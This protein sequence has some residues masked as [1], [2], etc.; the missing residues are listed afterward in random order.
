[1]NYDFSKMRLSNR[2]KAP[3]FNF[4]LTI[5][6]LTVFAGI[7]TFLSAIFTFNILG[8]EQYLQLIVTLSILL[9]FILRGKQIFE[10]Y[11]DREVINFTN[12]NVFPFFNE[13]VSD[14][15]PKYKLVNFEIKNLVFLKRL[16]FSITSKKKNFITLKYDI[17]YLTKKNKRFEIFFK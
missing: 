16:Y 11:S 14:K 9:I 4:Y 15:F 13:K 8:N 3:L 6:N 10:Y 17:S 7:I 2:A 12:R 1:L 5:V